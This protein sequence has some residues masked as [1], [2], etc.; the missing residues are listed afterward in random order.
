MLPNLWNEFC[1]SLR[2]TL[3]TRNGGMHSKQRL[4]FQTMLCVF[5]PMKVAS[6]EAN[7]TIIEVGG[8]VSGWWQKCQ[9]LPSSISKGTHTCGSVNREK[10]RQVFRHLKQPAQG[11]RQ[12]CS[13]WWTGCSSV[14]GEICGLLASPKL[15]VHW[16]SFP[17]TGGSWQRPCHCC[18]QRKWKWWDCLLMCATTTGVIKICHVGLGKI[19]LLKAKVSAWIFCDDQQ[20]HFCL[21]IRLLPLLSKPLW[22]AQLAFCHWHWIRCLESV[23]KTTLH[24]WWHQSTCGG[25]SL[26][27]N[28]LWFCH[29]GQWWQWMTWPCSLLCCASCFRKFS[30][31]LLQLTLFCH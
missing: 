1:I 12:I 25:S 14:W 21:D 7:I 2:R 27:L 17:T 8:V 16:Q 3:T 19:Q 23:R 4:L 26:L 10:T 13:C 11:H 29:I 22:L 31:F 20:D 18:C 6:V 15:W 28:F 24:R 30:F 5:G 9:M